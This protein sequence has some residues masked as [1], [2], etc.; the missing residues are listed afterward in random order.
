MTIAVLLLGYIIGSVP[1]AYLLAR[2]VG[3]VDVRLAGSGN[4]GAANVLRT[5]RRRSAG[6]AVALLDITK[7]AA[8][9]VCAQRL[10]ADEGLRAATGVAAIVG[11]IYPV[12]LNFKGGKGIATSCGVFGMLAPVAT[13]LAAVVFVAT[14]AW[15]RYVSLGS[16]VAAVL[17]APIA[18][19]LHATGAAVVSILAAAALVF[20]RHRSNIARLVRG[21]ERRLD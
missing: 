14:V 8:A 6:L 2:R 11:H 13:A 17:L 4:V 18:Y 10:G 5:T 16:L 3:G 9:V 19:L 12:W 20:Y 7:G 15:T 21:T 1:F